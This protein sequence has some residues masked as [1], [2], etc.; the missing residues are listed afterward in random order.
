MV[1]SA[2][3]F[4]FLLLCAFLG[5][6]MADVRSSTARCININNSKGAVAQKIMKP[7]RY[8]QGG[9][10]SLGNFFDTFNMVADAINGAQ[11]ITCSSGKNDVSSL[12][13]VISSVVG[14]NGASSFFNSVTGIGGDNGDNN[15]PTDQ[16]AGSFINLFNAI[17]AA[18]NIATSFGGIQ[19]TF[20]LADVISN[21]AGIVGGLQQAENIIGSITGTRD[22]PFVNNGSDSASTSSLSSLS[23]V[24]KFLSKLSSD[25]S[26]FSNGFFAPGF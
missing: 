22:G 2:P 10:D 24:T 16:D 25:F 4:Q 7:R 17:A 26:V 12:V 8:L 21:V 1:S 14:T 9:G 19:D 3:V 15:V 6:S 11:D 20:A 13:D 18:I 23:E 5:L